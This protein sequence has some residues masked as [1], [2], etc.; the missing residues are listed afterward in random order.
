MIKK[1]YHG[2]LEEFGLDI[3]E[4]QTFIHSDGEEHLLGKGI[5]LYE[6]LDQAKV[7]GITKSKSDKYAGSK[8]I[9]LEV[10]VDFQEDYYLDLDSREGQDFFFDQR[11]T[12]FY[13]VKDKNILKVKNYYTD[14]H[15]CDFL[16][17]KTS[18]TMLSKTFV[19][20]H[21]KSRQMPYR[22]TNQK[23]TDRDITRHFRTEKQFCLKDD[24][25]VKKISIIEL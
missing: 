4:S 2:T 11:N 16:V 1:F 21:K 14:S 3:Y 12:F 6:D 24:N 19:Y 22:H 23:K 20:I 15:F 25:L 13:L 10:E 5:Y 17:D 8:P 7:W 9:L 18:D